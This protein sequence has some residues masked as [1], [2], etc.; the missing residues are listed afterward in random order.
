MSS[1]QSEFDDVITMYFLKS[2]MAK[3]L[4]NLV[5]S[6]PLRK[7]LI[8]NKHRSMTASFKSGSACESDLNLE[9]ILGKIGM[10]F[11]LLK[12]KK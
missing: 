4:Y 9:K 11:C 7:D 1:Y 2:K 5:V 12:A 6:G 8:N 10:Y 3:S